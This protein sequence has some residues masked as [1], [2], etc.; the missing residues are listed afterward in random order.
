MR[1]VS[2]ESTNSKFAAERRGRGSAPGFGREQKRESSPGPQPALLGGS[3]S[4]LVV[5]TCVSGHGEPQIILAEIKTAILAPFLSFP[6]NWFPSSLL[7]WY[8]F[9]ES[10]HSWSPP[11]KGRPKEK[12]P[13]PRARGDVHP[14]APWLRV[15]DRIA[16][17]PAMARWNRHAE[18]ICRLKRTYENLCYWEE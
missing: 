2:G 10:F 18:S 9:R 4:L 7:L 12:K 13:A 5:S 1:S 17:R 3:F 16:Q 14:Q 6:L 15:R 8:I 11:S